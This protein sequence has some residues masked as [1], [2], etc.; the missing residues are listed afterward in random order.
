VFSCIVRMWL[1]HEV[2]LSYL[3][4]YLSYN[5]WTYKKKYNYWMKDQEMYDLHVLLDFFC[6]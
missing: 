5:Y 4:P 6:P 1:T 3:L 2:I